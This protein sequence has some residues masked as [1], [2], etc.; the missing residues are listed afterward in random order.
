VFT[1]HLLCCLFCPSVSLSLS[2]FLSS[3][4]KKAAAD[5]AAVLEAV[6]SGDLEAVER[7]ILDGAFAA[8]SCADQQ[9]RTPLHYA[10]YNGDRD[11]AAL[12]IDYDAHVEATDATVRKKCKRGGRC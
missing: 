8:S 10:A 3:A 5:D 12:L 4:A 11:M 2:L 9:L 7:L 6:I 1:F